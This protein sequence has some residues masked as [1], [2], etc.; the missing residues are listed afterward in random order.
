VVTDPPY[1]LGFM[2]KAWDA[3]GVSAAIVDQ[4]AFVDVFRL[5]HPA[6]C[7]NPEPVN[8]R[9]NYWFNGLMAGIDPDH[10]AHLGRNATV[11]R[12][13]S[14]SHVLVLEAVGV[15]LKTPNREG[16]LLRIESHEKHKSIRD[17][18]C[19]RAVIYAYG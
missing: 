4:R 14:I 13:P 19:R 3:S 1:E 7:F 16:A 15:F 18:G 8:W 2:G 10:V 17:A 9:E 5:L 6:Y 11:V 12:S